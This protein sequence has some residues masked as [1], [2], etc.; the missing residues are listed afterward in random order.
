MK[1]ML[2]HYTIDILQHREANSVGYRCQP[3]SSIWKCF[4]WS[5]VGASCR[6]SHCVLELHFLKVWVLKT[7]F[8]ITVTEVHD[9]KV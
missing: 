4:L 1:N 7:I 3:S 6:A 2:T 9:P 5:F 8:K